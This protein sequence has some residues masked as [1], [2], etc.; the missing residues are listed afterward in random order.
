MSDLVSRIIQYESEAMEDDE[1]FALFQELV[2]TGMAWQLQGSYGRM[3]Q[4]LIDEGLI[5]SK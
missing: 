5:S 3:A 4:F 1:V 2:D